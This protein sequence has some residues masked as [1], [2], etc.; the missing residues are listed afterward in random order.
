M[1]DLVP[2]MVDGAVVLNLLNRCDVKQNDCENCMKL[3]VYLHNWVKFVNIEYL[4]FDF[5]EEKDICPGFMLEFMQLRKRLKISFL[6]S[7][8]MKQTQSILDSYK[9]N[10]TFPSFWTPE[11][12]IRAIR[13]QNPGVT[14]TTLKNA[15]DF[16]RPI[17]DAFRASSSNISPDQVK[18]SDDRVDFLL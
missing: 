1:M 12:A 6:F 8:V 18:S 16:G 3:I 5:Q 17:G 7:G 15:V 14:E 9:C 13:I 11:D 4:V 2:V 10:D